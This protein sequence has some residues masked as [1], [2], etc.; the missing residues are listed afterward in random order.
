MPL[1]FWIREDYAMS[2]WL[3]KFEPKEKNQDKHT[4]FA[5]G[6]V[7]LASLGLGAVQYFKLGPYAN[8][9]FYTSVPSIVHYLPYLGAFGSLLMLW[10]PEFFRSKSKNHGT[11][12]SNE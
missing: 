6:F 8:A 12:N 3:D 2:D 11:E 5:G 7:L 4:R 1:A 9:D 10:K